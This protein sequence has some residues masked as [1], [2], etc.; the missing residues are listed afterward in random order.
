[1]IFPPVSHSTVRVK[2]GTHFS[3]HYRSNGSP[4]WKTRASLPPHL[5]FQPRETAALGNRSK[6]IPSWQPIRLQW[7]LLFWRPVTSDCSNQTLYNISQ[8]GQCTEN[9]WVRSQGE[10]KTKWKWK[11]HTAMWGLIQAH[12]RWTERRWGWNWKKCPGGVCVK[13]SG[14]LIQSSLSSHSLAQCVWVCVY[15]NFC[16][17][18]LGPFPA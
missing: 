5:C 16:F 15:T 18:S 6:Q 11:S 3:I 10:W 9:F 13:S 2:A 1:M 7:K 4:E 8:W 14:G 12:R 17:N